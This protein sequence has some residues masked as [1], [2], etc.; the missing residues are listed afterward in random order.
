MSAKRFKTITAN[1]RFTNTSPPAFRDPFWQV[2]LI[3]QAWNDNMAAQFLASWVLCLDE[4]MSIWHN[5][6]TC[7]GWVFCPRK[8]HPYGNEYHTLCCGLCGILCALEIG[9]S[10]GQR[11]SSRA[12]I[13]IQQLGEDCWID[14]ALPT[15][16]L[17]SMLYLTLAF[18][19]SKASLS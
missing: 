9:N 14:A 4:S 12:P 16:C 1:L 8:P 5:R 17:V 19:S 13:G 2:R 3:L 10:D 7:P 18:A 15:S 6:W 11:F